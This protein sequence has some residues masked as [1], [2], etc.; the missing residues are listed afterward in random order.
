MTV[1]LT[2]PKLACSACVTTVTKA[3]HSVDS[4]A[5]VNADPKTKQVNVETSK[6][7]V[8]IKSAIAAVGYPAN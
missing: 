1:S 3:I 8:E 6:S 5:T 2:V 7:E 4:S